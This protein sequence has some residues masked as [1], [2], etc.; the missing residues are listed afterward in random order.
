ME[1]MAYKCGRNYEFVVKN[2]ILSK[3]K[4][5]I[6]IKDKQKVAQLIKLTHNG[7]IST[8]EGFINTGM[9]VANIINTDN[10]KPI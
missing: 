7:A 4:Q 5:K 6:I 10:A 1:R 9:M 2:S 3:N 8:I